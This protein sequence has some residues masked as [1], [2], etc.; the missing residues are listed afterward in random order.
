MVTSAGEFGASFGEAKSGF[1]D[2]W[3]AVAKGRAQGGIVQFTERGE[4]IKGEG[5]FP[6]INVALRESAGAQALDICFGRVFE[7]K[8]EGGVAPPGIWLTEEKHG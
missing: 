2:A 7:G 5:L 4:K 8:P 1:T 3:I 6:E